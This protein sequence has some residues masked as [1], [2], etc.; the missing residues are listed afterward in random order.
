MKPVQVF[1][2][3]PSL[4]AP[5][6]GLRQLAYNLRWAWDH[7]TIELF[8][9][10]DSDL[11]ES[12]GHNPVLHAWVP[13]SRRNWRPRP[14][15]KP[16]WRTWTAPLKRT[17]RLS[18]RPNPPGSAAL[19]ATPEAAGGLFLGRVRLDRVPVDFRRRP[20]RAGRRPPEIGQRSGR[21]LVGVGLLYQQG[22]FRQYLNACRAGSRNLMKTT[23]F[24]TCR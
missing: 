11:W 17:G 15:T 10:L 21:A 23:I 4:P 2:V 18:D 1:Q 8:R 3:V 5:V 13:S 20:G 9:R 6:E 22:Y 12:T 19:M 24:T 14:R 7:D 16:S